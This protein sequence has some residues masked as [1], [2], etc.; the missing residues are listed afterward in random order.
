MLFFGGAK[1]LRSGSNGSMEEKLKLVSICL[2]LRLRGG[3]K[4]KNKQTHKQK[5]PNFIL[6]SADFQ[7]SNGSFS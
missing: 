3:L 6:L 5:S 7:I 4:K 2:T 1:N